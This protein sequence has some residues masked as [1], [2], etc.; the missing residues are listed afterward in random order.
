MGT[1]ASNLDCVGR[2]AEGRGQRVVVAEATGSTG[3][4]RGSSS[5]IAAAVSG[6]GGGGSGGGCVG[7]G[8]L[9][10]PL[11]LWFDSSSSVLSSFRLF[12]APF[13]KKAAH[14]EGSH[15]RL[16]PASIARCIAS[17]TPTARRALTKLHQY[18]HHP[19]A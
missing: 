3:G 10:K 9:S 1:L 13:T 17:A 14:N 11:S 19:L 5:R 4:G 16:M 6:G 18:L 8:A 15:P 12:Q 2:E 7:D